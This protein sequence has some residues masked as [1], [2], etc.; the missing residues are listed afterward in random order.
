MPETS[1]PFRTVRAS[2]FG[3][4]VE[5]NYYAKSALDELGRETPAGLKWRLE[6]L[7]EV[8]TYLQFDSLFDALL[9]IDKFYDVI[10][11]EYQNQLRMFVTN[12]GLVTLL[13][14]CRRMN[15]F[16]GI[17]EAEISNLRASICSH[18]QD[19]YEREWRP[20]SRSRNQK[21]GRAILEWLYFII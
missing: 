5:N 18:T 17:A 4:Q 9:T 2:A 10:P 11:S 1:V 14:F 3:S 16:K 13:D 12:G 15:V 21:T 20:D 7:T 8:L 6:K 19:I